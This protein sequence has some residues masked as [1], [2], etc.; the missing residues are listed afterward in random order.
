MKSITSHIQASILVLCAGLI[1]QNVSGQTQGNSLLITGVRIHTGTGKVIED[2]ALGIKADTIAFV[3]PRLNAKTAEYAEV[4]NYEGSELYPGLIA[5]NT[6]LG[7]TEIYA[8][9]ATRDFREVGNFKPNVR[10]IVA[11]NAD[12]KIVETVLANGVLFAQ[13]APQGGTIK[14]SSSAVKL[15]AW[16]WED[17]AYAID[18]GI[19][20][21][22]P[23]MFKN[24][25]ENPHLNVS[26]DKYDEHYAELKSYFTEAQAYAKRPNPL[27]VNLKL[28]AMRGIFDGNKR[29]YISADY[30]KEIREVINFKRFF[31]IDKVSIVGGR[32]SWMATDL[33]K[34]N[35]ISVV[36]QRVHSLPRYGQ[37]PVDEAYVLPAKLSDAGVEFCF[38]QMGQM[39][40]SEN[41]NLPFNIGTAIAYGVP[42]EKAVKAATLTPAKL[43][44]IDDITGSIEVGKEANFVISK[45]DLF[46]MHSSLIEALYIEGVSVKKETRQE[47]LYIKYKTKYEEEGLILVD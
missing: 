1:S 43:L 24:D 46:D 33:L 2:A 25:K 32:D 39:E 5:M 19:Y 27:D 15:S 16:N 26:D 34:E 23:S 45:G 44:G 41:R 22:W 37:D 28:E 20:L 30:I 38:S 11:Y 13:I 42:Y 36:V 31:E 18:E 8:V 7:L 9:R 6:S 12:S 17:A 14:G 3:G 35:N 29:L 21:D 4:Q 47:A 40:T 10:S